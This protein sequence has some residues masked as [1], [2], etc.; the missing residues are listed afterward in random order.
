MS[1][2]REMIA[3]IRKSIQE[4]DA[5]STFTN[6]FLYSKLKEHAKWLIRR[7][8]SAGKIYRSKSLFQSATCIP[9]VRAN[10][11]S[12]CCPI[13][14]DC[15]V[16]K[17]CDKIDELWEDDY[18]PIISTITSID[19]ST[20]FILLS[21]LNYQIKKDNP[22]SKWGKEKYAFYADNRIWWEN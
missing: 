4:K 8:I 13:K 6:K 19:G 17:T 21:A 18:G 5:D 3:K 11:I 22:Y 14:T 1:T 15:I 7:E 9:V 10:K 2:N 12:D 16:F 20:R